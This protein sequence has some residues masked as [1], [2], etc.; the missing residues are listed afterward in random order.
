VGRLTVPLLLA[1]VLSACGGTQTSASGVAAVDQ[2]PWGALGPGGLDDSPDGLVPEVGD[3]GPQVMAEIT[4]PGGGVPTLPQPS[5]PPPPVFVT[6]AADRTAT[7]ASPAEPRDPEPTPTTAPPPPA[8]SARAVERLGSDELRSSAARALGLVRYDWQRGLPGW[9]LRFLP[10]RAGVRGY[11][12]PDTR[13]IEVFVRADDS[14]EGLAH[15]VAHELGH[16]VDVTHLDDGERAA[17]RTA[18]GIPGG[19]PWF[20]GVNGG[21]DFASGAG[22]FAESFAWTFAG[23][24]W[25]SDLGPPPDRLQT[26]LVGQLASP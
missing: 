12:Y 24:P 16:A 4:L 7:A 13:V 17:W 5:V 26:A 2:A 15:V 14:P 10:G 11:T 23:P 8:G 18:R 21:T 9:Q 20:P 25:F 19:A 1:L 3:P 22:D 6:P